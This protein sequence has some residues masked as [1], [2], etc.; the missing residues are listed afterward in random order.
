MGV[1]SVVS[2]SGVCQV[3]FLNHFES[4]RSVYRNRKRWNMMWLFLILVAL[5]SIKADASTNVPLGHWGYDFIERLETKGVVRNMRDGSRPLSRAEMAQAVAQAA[6]NREG[7][8]VVEREQLEKLRELFTE[9]SDSGS[10]ERI[11]KGGPLWEWREKQWRMYVD[12]VGRWKGTF[13]RGARDRIYQQTSGLRIRGDFGHLGF[14]AEARDTQESGTRAYDTLEDIFEEGIGYAKVKRGVANYDETVAYLVWELPWFEVIFGK[15][16]LRWGPGWRGNVILSAYG[17]SFDMIKL[18]ARYERFT[19]TSVTGFLRTDLA[20]SSW[21]YDGGVKLIPRKKRLAAHR[22]E[23]S[24]SEK[25]DVGLSEMVVYGDRS[26]EPDYVNPIMFYWSA[27]HHLGDQDNAMMALDVEVRPIRNLKLYGVWLLDDLMKSRLGTDWFGNKFAMSGGVLW[28]DPF[29]LADTDVRLEYVRI[30]PWVYTHTFR[31]NSYQHYGWALGHWLGPN[32]D[33]VFVRI[34]HQFT[35]DL[36]ASVFFE[37]ERQGQNEADRDVG[38]EL[39]EGHQSGDSDHKRFLDGILEKHTSFGFE[40]V[41]EPLRN[42]IVRAGVR[43]MRSENVLLT[44]DRRGEIKRHRV[45]VSIAYNY[46]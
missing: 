10:L 28:L 12:Y 32:A 14:Y 1:I 3:F 43:R 5:C 13:H 23:I 44:N 4:M 6:Q 39:D 16:R 46:W 26:W 37:Q 25:V 17:P 31:I 15:D 30:D 35:G 45:S 42:L 29:G 40:A 18:K 22:L 38:G 2:G 7:L 9:P 20:D 24:V 21:S 11:L 33:D 34:G 27:E 8:S 41:Y 36:S 19:F